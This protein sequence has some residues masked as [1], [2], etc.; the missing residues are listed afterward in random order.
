MTDPETGSE[1]EATPP[2]SPM[3]QDAPEGGI[4]GG[5]E[6]DATRHE[7]A[8]GGTIPIEDEQPRPEPEDEESPVQQENA[9][10][11]LDQPSNG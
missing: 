5:Q 2:G 11:S 7:D 4:P 9:E 8:H 10:T 1:P 3:R 6:D